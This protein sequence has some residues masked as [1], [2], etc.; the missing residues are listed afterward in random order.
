MSDASYMCILLFNLA[1]S[2]VGK[3]QRDKGY[4]LFKEETE[5]NF[6][7]IFPFIPNFEEQIMI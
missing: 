5:I 4:V 1:A 7:N 3:L 6:H 2:H